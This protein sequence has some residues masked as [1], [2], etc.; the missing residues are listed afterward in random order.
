MSR[1]GE[2]VAAPS[3]ALL[4][5]FLFLAGCT[6]PPPSFSL[7]DA[8]THLDVLAGSI[9][10]RPVSS[11]QN[12]DARAYLVGRLRAYGFAVET[13][14]AE[15]R[16]DDLGVTAHVVNIVAT[17]AGNEPGAIALVAHYDSV[18]D[19]PGAADD[20][21][22]SAIV[23]EAARA[24]TQ[25]GNRRHTLMVLLTDGEEA[26]LL[27]AASAVK[28]EAFPTRAL[29]YVNVEAIGS[30]GPL[31]L[32]ETGPGNAGLL[33][34]WARAVAPRG[35]SYA[36]E[37]YRYLPRD[38]DFSMLK[39]SGVPGLNLALVGDGYAYHTDRDV[40]TRISDRTLATAG[41][42]VVRLVETL[43]DMDL[44]TRTAD[45]A[46]YFDVAGLFGVWYSTRWS[47]AINVGALVLGALA[48]WRVFRR[49]A[50][51]GP[52]ALMV[53]MGSSIMVFAAATGAMLAAAWL[54][55]ATREVYH[56]W[57]AH[58]DRF[59]FLLVTAGV[60]GGWFVAQGL[61][62]LPWRQARHPARLWCSTLPVWVALAGLSAWFAEGAAFVWTIPLLVA[63]IGLL[64]APID[65]PLVN[66]CRGIRGARRRCPVL[67]T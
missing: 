61:S 44:G 19:G 1:Y 29:A 60:S 33:G 63:A 59:F 24:L 17:R 15:S 43:D 66:P 12:A 27:G 50:M 32:F 49:L 5:L 40:P 58:P 53:A 16:R 21:F 31:L 8:R 26:G 67:D 2:S 38:T 7:A 64:V 57:Y 48:W 4:F 34:A 45:D 42:T 65:R 11:Q 54:L 55:R 46:T 23:L 18:P 47:H 39:R 9:G 14:E 56:P 36:R 6:T 41:A 37:I 20:G 10:S 22:G 28:S 52:R 30:D 62:Y 25:N 13:L 35:A 51:S 3:I